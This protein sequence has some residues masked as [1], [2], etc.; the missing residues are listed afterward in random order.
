VKRYLSNHAAAPFATGRDWA[1][2]LHACGV[3][4]K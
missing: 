2:A 3:P 1:Q 4:M